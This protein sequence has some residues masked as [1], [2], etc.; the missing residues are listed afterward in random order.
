MTESLGEEIVYSLNGKWIFTGRVV[1]RIPATL[2]PRR[3]GAVSPAER[4]VLEDAHGE[5]FTTVAMRCASVES[6]AA[7][8]TK[9]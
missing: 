9:Q 2:T 3:T 7:S 5:R 6:R 4:L 8:L 1:A